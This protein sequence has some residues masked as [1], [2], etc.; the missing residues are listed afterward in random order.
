MVGILQFSSRAPLALHLL[1]ESLS[2]VSWSA[3][4]CHTENSRGFA[5][6]EVSKR[7]VVDSEIEVGTCFVHPS[8][9]R[10]YMACR[11][12]TPRCNCCSLAQKSQNGVSTVS[13]VWIFSFI[14]HLTGLSIIVF[15]FS[16]GVLLT[17]LLQEARHGNQSL[18]NAAYFKEAQSTGCSFQDSARPLSHALCSIGVFLVLF[19]KASALHF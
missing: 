6:V 9:L 14:I 17:N 3:T 8:S 5:N 7:L 2:A 12:N 10:I 16:G 4:F 15:S 11:Q 13:F 19:E 1:C 18:V